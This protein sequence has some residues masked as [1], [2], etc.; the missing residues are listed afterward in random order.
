MLKGQKGE[1]RIHVNK[2]EVLVSSLYY[3]PQLGSLL[4]GYNFG[5]FQLWDLMTFN[6]TYTSPICNDHIPIAHFII[7]VSNIIIIYKIDILIVFN[8]RSRP[9]IRKL[10]VIFGRCTVVLNAI[11]TIYL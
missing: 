9:M 8:L 1:D 7:Q 4:V 11:L 10:F 3:C 5:A 2:I 6:L